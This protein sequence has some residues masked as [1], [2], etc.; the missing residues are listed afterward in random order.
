MHYAA[1]IFIALAFCCAI[2]SPTFAGAATK[3]KTAKEISCRKETRAKKFGVHLIDKRAF[4]K[5]CMAR[6]A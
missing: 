4:M 3:S 1:R 2:S 6:P 5:E